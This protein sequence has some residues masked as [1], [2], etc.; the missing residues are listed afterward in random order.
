MVLSTLQASWAGEL[1]SASSSRLRSTMRKLR[2]LPF[3]LALSLGSTSCWF[4]KSTPPRVFVPPPPAAR[5]SVATTQPQLRPP[6]E[7]DMPEEATATGGIPAAM[8]PTEPPPPT[9]PRRVPSPVRATTPPPAQIPPDVPPAPRLGQIFTA[10][11]LREY[12]RAVDES[13]ERVRRNLSKVA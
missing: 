3:I 5:P 4:R 2:L 7:I 12:N 11:Q 1:P 10:E 13:L 6:P 8:P 9:P